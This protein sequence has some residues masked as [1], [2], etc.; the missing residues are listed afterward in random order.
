MPAGAGSLPYARAGDDKGKV[1]L[2]ETGRGLGTSLVTLLIVVAFGTPLAYLLA[3]R[4]FPGAR[5][6]DTLID[7]IEKSSDKAQ[8][9]KDTQR[10]HEI[11]VDEAPWA[12]IVH[13]RNPRAMSKKVKG[14]IFAFIFN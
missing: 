3:R 9:L 7:R 5:L 12:F 1:W 2:A 10:A 8:I 13:D 6:I 14:F 11:I 4:P